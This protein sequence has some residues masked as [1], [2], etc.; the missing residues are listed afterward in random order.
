MSSPARQSTAVVL[1]FGDATRTLAAD[2]AR[3][4]GG[5]LLNLEALSRMATEELSEEGEQFLALQKAGALPP[6]QLALPLMLRAISTHNAP[7][8]LG[9]YPRLGTHLAKL[10]A[11][12]GTVTLAVQ[13]GQA[14]TGA[15]E[16]LAAF[17]HRRGTQMSTATSRSDVLAAMA[18]SGITLPVARR[19]ID[20][21]HEEQSISKVAR[22]PAIKVPPHGRP[23]PKVAAYY[24]S[25]L[26]SDS[27]GMQPSPGGHQA[28]TPTDHPA[29]PSNA[30][31]LPRA[32]ERGLGELLPR[33]QL[34][35]SQRARAVLLVRLARFPSMAP[36]LPTCCLPCTPSLFGMSNH[37]L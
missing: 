30:A 8:I 32:I 26:G 27:H 14:S 37:V 11:A 10:E 22:A 25:R 12:T 19:R 29:P 6:F 17:L 13:A 36:L 34:L 1:M 33:F 9:G 18:T 15:D 35:E 21:Q 28:N 24:R 3:T 23:S 2:V 20:M 31:R 4:C 16:S 5:T 7:F